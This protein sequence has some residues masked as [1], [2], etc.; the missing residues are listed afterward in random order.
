MAESS[1]S[2]VVMR[3]CNNA[4]PNGGV[5]YA[6]GGNDSSNTNANIGSRLDKLK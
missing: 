1:D 5:A 2:R 6:N 4:N 3:S